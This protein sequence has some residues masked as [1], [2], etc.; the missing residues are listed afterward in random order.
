[1][2]DV[3]SDAG[4]VVGVDGSASSSV[5][6]DWAAREAALHQWPLTLLHVVPRPP[7][8]ETLPAVASLT[9][10]HGNEFLHRATTTVKE[11][12][13]DGLIVHQ[14]ILRGDA[15][16]ALTEA[17]RSARMIV[18]GRR[19]LGMLGRTLLGS[20]SRSV[21]HHAHCPVA[22]IHDEDPLMP[23]PQSAPV[24][25]GID[26]SPSSAAAMA[27]A[28]DEAARRGV[29]LIAVHAWTDSAIYL[30]P[31]EEWMSV[32]PRVAK[33]VA[34]QLKSWQERYPT[35]PVQRVVVQDRPAHQL[36]E[37]SERA[38]LVV[39]G[40]RG[41]GGLAGMLLGSVSAAVAQRSRMPVIVARGP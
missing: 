31:N 35:V 32:Q 8:G 28:F 17:S 25:V 26:C 30:L 10:G 19:G 16:A 33:I 2:S 14:R 18:V 13:G 21:V 37:L 36:L 7:M 1:M 39:V 12:V 38:Q 11:A 34:D 5:A 22:V 23:Q 15:G 40:S 29:P 41:R 4:V 24:V 27:I 9:T 20:V 6:V 3:M